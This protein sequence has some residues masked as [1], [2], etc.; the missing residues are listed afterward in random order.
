MILTLCPTYHDWAPL[1]PAVCACVLQGSH[2]E[3]TAGT[4]GGGGTSPASLLQEGLPHL[5]GAPVL[6]WGWGGGSRDGLGK[7]GQEQVQGVR[8]TQP[9][10]VSSPSRGGLSLALGVGAGTGPRGPVLLV[11]SGPVVPKGPSSFGR[12]PLGLWA[13][14]DT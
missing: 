12:Q 14:G 11:S 13:G 8:Q 10:R 5:P 7:T 6:R 2:V 1:D 4:L 9:S 3:Q